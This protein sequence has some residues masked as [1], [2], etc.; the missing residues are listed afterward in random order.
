MLTH[1]YTSPCGVLLLA[2]ENGHVC[3]CLW[4]CQK[5]ADKLLRSNAHIALTDEDTRLLGLLCHQLDEYFQG[6][7]KAF[8]I[9]LDPH[10]GTPFQQRVWR[11]IANVPYGRTITY[12][13]L[14]HTIG[15]PTAIRAAANATGDNPLAILVP[16]HRIIGT[17][18]S[19]TGFAGGI[20]AKQFLLQLEQARE[21]P[22][23][24]SISAP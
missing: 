9:P 12:K 11:A 4:A 1:F 5:E 2:I 18:G 10:L 3:R 21:Q 7:R 22:S 15:H 14:A 24:T 19:L 17:N 16:C 6:R 8:Q 23:Q 13:Q 20:P